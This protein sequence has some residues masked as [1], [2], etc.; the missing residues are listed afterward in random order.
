[1]QDSIQPWACGT[2]MV[3]GATDSATDLHLI[4]EPVDVELVAGEGDDAELRVPQQP[5]PGGGR[6]PGLHL[7]GGGEHAAGGLPAGL[8][9]RGATSL[10]PSSPWLTRAAQV[11]ATTP[12]D[13]EPA[14][15]GETK[16][17]PVQSAET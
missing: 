13:L 12:P 8:R 14:R 3:V 1:M 15:V 9:A 10:Y 2:A 5:E 4:G 7:H 17:P 11:A 16:M 6:H